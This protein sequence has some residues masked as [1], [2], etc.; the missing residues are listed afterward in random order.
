VWTNLIQIRMD[1]SHQ[2]GRE[3]LDVLVVSGSDAP[4]ALS[5]VEEAFDA[6]AQGVNGSVGRT[7]YFSGRRPWNHRCATAPLDIPA[8]GLA[9]AS[10][11]AEHS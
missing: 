5:P 7:L 6:V 2:E 3:A 4:S 9:V 8:H 10:L 11:I 1:T